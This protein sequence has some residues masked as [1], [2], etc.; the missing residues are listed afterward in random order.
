M[1]RCGLHGLRMNRR[2]RRIRIPR[3]GDVRLRRPMTGAPYEH[4]IDHP[5]FCP[6]IPPSLPVSC[7][8]P[9]SAELSARPH[10]RKW[11]RQMAVPR[12]SSVSD[13]GGRRCFLCLEQPTKQEKLEKSITRHVRASASAPMQHLLFFLHRQWVNRFRLRGGEIQSPPSLRQSSCA[14]RDW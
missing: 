7:A 4:D 14:R 8:L 9:T 3:T 1:S 11:R 6:D 12:S 10:S 5:G 13:P 2:Y